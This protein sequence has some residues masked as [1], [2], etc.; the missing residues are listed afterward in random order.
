MKK[1]NIVL[2]NSKLSHCPYSLYAA[3]DTRGEDPISRI[4]EE[5]KPYQVL[6]GGISLISILVYLPQKFHKGV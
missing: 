4:Y 1:E 2:N 5:T 6:M 3:N